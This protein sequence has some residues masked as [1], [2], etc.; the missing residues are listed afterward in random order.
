MLGGM[1]HAAW[2]S[3]STVPL[4]SLPQGCTG[5]QCAMSCLKLSKGW[6][7]APETAVRAGSLRC[8]SQITDLE[9]L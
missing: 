1:L 6:Q 5:G 8:L 3:S 4:D 9:I 2:L 7:R